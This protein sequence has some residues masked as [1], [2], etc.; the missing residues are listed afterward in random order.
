ML[1]GCVDLFSVVDLMP[2]PAPLPTAIKILRG[3]YRRDREPRNPARPPLAAPRPPE[4]LGP[5]AL[6]VWRELARVLA[7][8]RLLTQADRLALALLCD[9]IAEYRAARA[10]VEATGATFTVTTDSGKVVRPRPEVAIAA[11][12]H[13]RARLM[14]A[15]F[16]LTPAGRRRVEAL[17]SE[18]D[19]RR[20][21]FA[22]L[23]R[24]RDPLKKYLG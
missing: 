5:V 11:D 3:T 20:N 14:L 6:E 9:V 15:E 19:L 4:W 2:G 24:P 22:F 18:E 8:M 17:P 16:G 7:R 21:P 1:A 12:A 23:G 13:R 10:V